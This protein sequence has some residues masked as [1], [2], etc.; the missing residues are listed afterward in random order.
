MKSLY[1]LAA[2]FAQGAF[3][4]FSTRHFFAGELSLFSQTAV[5]AHCRFALH[6]FHWSSQVLDYTH[7]AHH[8]NPDAG[9][10]L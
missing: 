9:H 2:F 8:W 4:I 7:A 10:F 1:R 5:V 6:T 3:V